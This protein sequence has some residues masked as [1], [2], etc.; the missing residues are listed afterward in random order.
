ADLR[1][2]IGFSSFAI[3]T[4]YALANASAFTLQGAERRW[5]RWLAALGVG[6]CILLAFSLPQVAVIGGL[7]L[8]AVGSAVWSVAR[9]RRRP[10]G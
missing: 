7:V 5:P 6:L 2:A 10:P 9:A 1:G 8:L 3:L 4:Y